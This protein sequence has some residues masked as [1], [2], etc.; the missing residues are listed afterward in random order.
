MN[1][2]EPQS[3]REIHFLGREGKPQGFLPKKNLS[4]ILEIRDKE[5]PEAP[6]HSC[7]LLES[8]KETLEEIAGI[9][10]EVDNLKDSLIEVSEVIKEAKEVLE[11]YKEVKTGVQIFNKL[12]KLL[13]WFAGLI[14]AVT[15]I[16]GVIKVGGK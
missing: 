16:I 4:K 8:Y 3:V 7:I 2:E 15:V 6:N 10:Q 14:A 5:C 13:V 12:S 11:V 1:N 9:D